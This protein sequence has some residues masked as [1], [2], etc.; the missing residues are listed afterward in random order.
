MWGKYMVE[1]SGWGLSRAHLS[2]SPSW[3]LVSRGQH[4][5]ERLQWA[6]SLGI[7]QQQR[8][9]LCWFRLP[10]HAFP[11]VDFLSPSHPPRTSPHSPQQSSAWVCSPNPTFQYPALVC[12]GGHPLKLGGQGWGQ[13]PV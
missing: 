12:S 10:P 3:C 8:S 2:G 6:S 5:G 13:Y 9:V 1:A 7:T 11:C 4:R